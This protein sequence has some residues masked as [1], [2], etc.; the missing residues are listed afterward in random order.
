LCFDFELFGFSELL[1]DHAP[2]RE[3]GLTAVTLSHPDA[4]LM[5]FHGLFRKHKHS[6]SPVQG[7]H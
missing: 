4:L 6:L 1:K 5:L 3:S 7:L 2:D